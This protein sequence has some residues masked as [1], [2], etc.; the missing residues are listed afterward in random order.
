MTGVLGRA[1]GGTGLSEA[2][3]AGNVLTS[4]G[5]DWVSSAPAAAGSKT[6]AVFTPRDN[7]PPATAFATL[8]TRNSVATL[9]FDDGSETTQEAAVFVGIIPEGAVL[10]SGILVRIKWT[11]VS[12]TSGA[13]RWGVQWEREGTDLDADSFDAATEAHSTTSGTSG[14]EVTTSITCTAIDSLAAGERFRLRVYRDSADTTNDTMTGDAEL[15]AVE[16]R[17]AN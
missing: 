7:Q 15:I 2:G 9:R 11:A 3:P 10:T 12:A 13:C 4:N 8:L 14:I 1:N 17:T 16:V 5:T 6:I